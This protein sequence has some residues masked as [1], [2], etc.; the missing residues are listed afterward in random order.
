MGRKKTISFHHFKKER[1]LLESATI[2]AIPRDSPE[3]T[4]PDNCRFDACIVI[5][6]DYQL[7]NSIYE[8]ELSD[9]EYL[10]R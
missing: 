3:I 1:N 8:S 9:G 10:S 4:F 6:K 2:L 7:D 5:S